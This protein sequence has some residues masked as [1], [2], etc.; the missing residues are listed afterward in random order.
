MPTKVLFNGT[1]YPVQLTLYVRA[2][3]APGRVHSS[4][5]VLLG[6]GDETAVEYGD[7]LNRF[8]EG[9]ELSWVQDGARHMQRR[10]VT[11]RDSVWEATLNRSEAL[12]VCSLGEVDV[13]SGVVDQES[14][15]HTDPGLPRAVSLPGSQR[16]A[17]RLR[18]EREPRSVPPRGRGLRV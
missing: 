7:P 9:L 13:R 5:Q 6:P 10:L 14:T 12:L 8:L 16:D 11:Q 4:M 1:P 15:I 18:D 2:G 3:I 17:P